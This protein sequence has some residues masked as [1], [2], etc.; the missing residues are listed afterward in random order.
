MSRSST[1]AQ[2]WS[3]ALLRVNI[4]LVFLMHGGQKW[5]IWGLHDTAARFSLLHVPFPLV[6]ALF[7]MTIELFCGLFLILGLFTRL[8]TVPLIIVMLAA[9]FWVYIRHG[10]FLTPT[11][12]GCEYVL[13]RLAALIAIRTLGPGEASMD[14]TFGGRRR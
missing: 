10:F 12:P 14:K 3:V 13:L 5:F 8:A 9:L 2:R 6:S 7:A 1:E 4:G 11:N